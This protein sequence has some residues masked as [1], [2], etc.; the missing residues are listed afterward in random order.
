MPYLQS[1]VSRASR[2]RPSIR[3]FWSVLHDDRL[4]YCTAG[5]TVASVPYVKYLL[6]VKVLVCDVVP[7]RLGREIQRPLAAKK[8]ID[9]HPRIKCPSPSLLAALANEQRAGRGAHQP[10][11]HECELR[12]RHQ[13][14]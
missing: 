3:Q 1:G 8:H 9:L 13:A 4:S 7:E 10:S 6:N 14:I 2:V 12:N 5:T 11:S